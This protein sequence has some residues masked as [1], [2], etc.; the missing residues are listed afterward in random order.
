MFKPDLP[1]ED[2]P[3]GLLAVQTDD[4]TNAQKITHISRCSF[5]ALL[6]CRCTL[7]SEELYHLSCDVSI[8]TASH[9]IILSDNIGI[10]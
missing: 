5:A 10:A 1:A 2:E 9:H 8:I 3:L 6:T 4:V 7:Y